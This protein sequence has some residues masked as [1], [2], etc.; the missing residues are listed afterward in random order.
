MREYE[1]SDPEMQAEKEEQELLD[2]MISGKLSEYIGGEGTTT[3]GRY[4]W[5]PTHGSCY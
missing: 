2:A 3:A 5:C 4:Q 1:R